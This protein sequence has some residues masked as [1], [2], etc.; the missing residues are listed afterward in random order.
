WLPFMCAVLARSP[1]RCPLC[2][3]RP[4]TSVRPARPTRST[5][6]LGDVIQAVQHV[7][8]EVERGLVVECR[9]VLQCLLDHRDPQVIPGDVLAVAGH[10]VSLSCLWFPEPSG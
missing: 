1:R 4:P 2:P 3:V 10:A 9:V 5:Y 8:R 7:Y 6:L